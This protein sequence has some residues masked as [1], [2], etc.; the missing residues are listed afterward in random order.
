MIALSAILL[1]VTCF[2]KDVA[3][4]RFIAEKGASHGFL[5][6]YNMFLHLMV[7]LLVV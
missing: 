4:N 6:T 3:V 5:S 1:I 2:W 7:P